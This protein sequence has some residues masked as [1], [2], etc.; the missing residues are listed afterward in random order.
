MVVFETIRTRT[1]VTRD[2]SYTCIIWPLLHIYCYIHLEPLDGF[3]LIIYIHDQPHVM[4]S[5]INSAMNWKILSST[6]GNI[7]LPAFVMS[8]THLLASYIYP[9]MDREAAGSLIYTSSGWYAQRVSRRCACRIN[10]PYLECSTARYNFVH[11]VNS[12]GCSISWPRNSSR[13]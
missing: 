13:S 2:P 7:S 1:T 3:I 8:P 10:V 4:I 11:W 5:K 12:P 9:Q 6:L